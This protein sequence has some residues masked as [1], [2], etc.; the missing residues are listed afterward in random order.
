MSYHMVGQ[1]CDAT[2]ESAITSDSVNLKG[3]AAM[4]LA[5]WS[6]MHFKI[7]LPKRF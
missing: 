1:S 4:A 7:L 5:V 6:H 3:P 2:G